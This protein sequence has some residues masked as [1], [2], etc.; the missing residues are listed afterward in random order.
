MLFEMLKSRFI[1]AKRLERR[2]FSTLSL[3]LTFSMVTAPEINKG[4]SCH[5]LQEEKKKISEDKLKKYSTISPWRLDCMTQTIQCRNKD[6]KIDT[7][8]VS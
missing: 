8:L 3:G 6:V 2:F 4:K 7:V 1:V 5:E